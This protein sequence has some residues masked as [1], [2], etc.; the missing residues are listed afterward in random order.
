MPRR[1]DLELNWKRNNNM[2]SFIITILAVFTLYPQNTGYTKKGGLFPRVDDTPPKITMIEPAIT[3]G[4]EYISK[5]NPLI[6]KGKVEDTSG[7]GEFLFNGQNIELAEGGNFRIPAWLA[8]G[9]N[10]IVLRAIDNNFNVTIDTLL[11][12]YN[13]QEKLSGG[14]YYAFLIGINSYSGKWERLKNPINDVTKLDSVLRFGYRFDEIIT[15]LDSQATRENILTKLDWFS[16]N[17]KENDNLLIYYAGHG[18]YNKKQKRGYWVPI[19]AKTQAGYISNGELRERIAGIYTKHTLLITDACFAGDIILSGDTFRGSE[20]L[21][22]PSDAKE[23]TRYYGQMYSKKSRLALT[24]GDIEPVADGGKENHSIF[25]YYLI[26]TLKE[27]DKK[28]F[29]VQDL[30]EKFKIPVTDKSK[31]TPKLGVIRDAGDE[32]GQFIFFRK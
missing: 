16:D 27:I 10:F 2:K 8:L 26:K 6:I 20:K 11:V 14:K 3:R 28:Y 12:H 18:S 21:D 4:T 31:Q 29:N 23:L 13:F 30:F 19:D 24:S 9:L 32:D 22:D 1:L 15:L 5:G 25:A 17:L 7:I